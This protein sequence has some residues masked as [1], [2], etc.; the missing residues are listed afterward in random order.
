[1]FFKTVDPDAYVV[2]AALTPTVAMDGRNLNNLVFLQRMYLAGAGDCFDI[3]SA[4]GYG[5]WSGASDQRLR[6]TVINY[7]HHLFVR[8]LMVRHG[9]AEKP[10]WISEMAWNVVPPELPATYGRVTPAQQAAYAVTA[11]ERAQVAWPW[12]GAIN[13]WF[14]K[15]AA[16]WEK[17][18]PFYYFRLMEPDFTPMPVYEAI[19]DYTATADT[20]TPRPAWEYR[21]QQIRPLLFLLSRAVLFYAWLRY[22]APA[23]S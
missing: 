2:A 15:R 6:P 18:E 21:W 22:L 13:Y 3:F 17:D 8:D 4:Q 11:Y 5:L 1:M 10:I 9:D 12:V 16:D 19:A 20:V 23:P 7:P 14:F